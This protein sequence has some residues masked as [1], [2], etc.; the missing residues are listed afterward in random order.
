MH[1]VLNTNSAQN[2][3]YTH[4]LWEQVLSDLPGQYYSTTCNKTHVGLLVVLTLT[5]CITQCANVAFANHGESRSSKMVSC[6]TYQEIWMA[7]GEKSIT[8]KQFNHGQV[9]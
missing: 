8:A 6:V 2:S 7:S 4:V 3:E 1:Y 5:G 9:Y